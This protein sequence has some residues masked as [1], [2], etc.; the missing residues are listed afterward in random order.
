MIEGVY[1]YV[2]D[3]TS[4]VSDTVI[5]SWAGEFIVLYCIVLYCITLFS[6]RLFNVKICI[7]L[8]F[9]L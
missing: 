5:A 4:V 3:Y 2:D 1:P 9:R 8:V 6:F 7:I